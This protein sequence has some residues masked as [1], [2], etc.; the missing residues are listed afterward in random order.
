MQQTPLKA[1]L[2]LDQGESSPYVDGGLFA[3]AYDRHCIDVKSLKVSTKNLPEVFGRVTEQAPDVLLLDSTLGWQSVLRMA[4]RLR[5]R[6]PSLPIVLV[7]NTRSARQEPQPQQ[8]PASLAGR[9]TGGAGSARGRTAC[10]SVARTIRHMHERLELQRAL[11]HTA[12]RDELTGL[13]DRR[14]FMALATEQ[15]RL[16]RDMRQRVLLFFADLDGHKWINDSFGHAEGDRAISLVAASIRQTFRKTDVT[17]RLSGDE[18]VAMILEE[19]GRDAEAI[20]Q[21][22]QKSLANCA[23]A[24]ARYQLSLSI[25]VAHFD[26]DEP[27]GVQ[28]LL[29]QADAALYRH[30]GDKRFRVAGVVSRRVKAMQIKRAAQ[31]MSTNMTA[32]LAAADE[33][34]ISDTVLLANI[35]EHGACLITDRHWS[36]GRQVVL[37]DPLLNYASEAEVVYCAPHESRRFAIGLKFAART[38]PRDCGR[39]SSPA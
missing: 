19:P 4:L 31:R 37:S 16:A 35:S 32:T 36:A 11:L 14:G 9:S 13:H 3:E 27:V 25:G 39:I 7:P 38:T 1:M 15:L 6:M 22:L 20:C 28:E 12:L 23:G 5:R 2:L 34:S 24:E 17:G 18:F 26:P 8:Q 21:R 29:R 30:K 33:R 10:D